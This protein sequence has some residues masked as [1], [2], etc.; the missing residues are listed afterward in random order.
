MVGLLL[1]TPTGQPRNRL[2]CALLIGL[3]II[4]G[5]GSRKFSFLL[6]SW[7]AK[8]AGDILYATMAFWL[9]VFLFPRLSTLRA[10]LAAT[11]F[12]FGIESLKF[13]EA[14]WMVAIRHSKAGALVFGSG[15]HVS[16][17]ICYLIGV[18]LA[19]GIDAAI[20]QIGGARRRPA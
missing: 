8:N 13:Y 20:K 7:L 2:V 1:V 4:L 10:A 6:P 15:F 19:V 3:T 5:L 12:C 16:N 17:L 11:L 14:G 9:V 18:L